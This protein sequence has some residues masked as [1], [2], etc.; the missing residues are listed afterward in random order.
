MKVAECNI[1]HGHKKVTQ[2]PHITISY[3]LY[4]TYQTH[5]IILAFYRIMEKQ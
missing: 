2:T 4:L 3:A 5:M 1:H